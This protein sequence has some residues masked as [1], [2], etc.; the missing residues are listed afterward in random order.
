M[1]IEALGGAALALTL[2]GSAYLAT[3]TVAAALARPRR[4]AAPAA[5]APSV[6]IVVPAHNESIGLLRTLH[7]LR[8]EVSR[9][10]RTRVVVVADNCSDDTAA[11][12]LAA[13]VDVL[14]RHDAS[15]RGKGYALQFAF[16]AI[17]DADWFVVIDADTD[18][19]PGF[20]AAMRACMTPDA[21][22]LQC[23]YGVRDPLAGRRQTLADVALG[24]WNVLRP[25]GRSALGLSAGILGNGFALSRS[26]LQ[27]VP[28]SAHSIVEDVEY[29]LLLVRS[30]L[31]VRWVD[32]AQ[33]RGDMPHATA[34]ASEQRARWEGGRLRLAAERAPG[35]LRSVC[36]GQGRLA[37]PLLDLLLLPLAWHVT[38]LLFALAMASM[39]G[40]SVMQTL[41]VAGLATVAMH[42]AVALRL[43]GAGRTHLR[44]LLGVPAHVA[45][46][47]CLAGATWR[48]SRRHAAWVRSARQAP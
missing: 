36:R 16:N 12:A 23:R 4:C 9:C 33:V 32:A 18:V 21:D 6:V 44:A 28:Y 48:A 42:V 13:G 20:L 47:L 41:A 8:R 38:L 25:R 30:G 19:A 24:A 1:W 35:L 46:K 43:I 7:S 34:A 40:E 15:L 22:A 26:T 14:E 11:V 45:W 37:D 29:H 31:F 27:A 10:S 5:D 3:L 2:P 17:E 39:T